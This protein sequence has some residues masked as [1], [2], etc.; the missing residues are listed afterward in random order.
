M[1]LVSGTF[2]HAWQPL[3]QGSTGCQRVARSVEAQEAG[4]KKNLQPCRAWQGV[5]PSARTHTMASAGTGRS[6]P[7]HCIVRGDGERQA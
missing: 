1:N 7:R 5:E 3:K 2:L 6:R 4:R